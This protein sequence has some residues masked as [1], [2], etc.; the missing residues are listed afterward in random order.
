MHFSIRCGAPY[1]AGHHSAYAT[2]KPKGYYCAQNLREKPTRTPCDDFPIVKGA[3]QSAQNAVF[4]FQAAVF[5]SEAE[6][7][8][9]RAKS[10]D[11]Q[12]NA[13][14]MSCAPRVSQNTEGSGRS[15]GQETWELRISPHNIFGTGR[16]LSAPAFPKTVY[17]PTSRFFQIRRKRGT[18]QVFGIGRFL[19]RLPG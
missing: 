11:S 3:T 7:S 5:C 12:Q 15:R 16:Y 4:R 13:A 10:F 19:G 18:S 9:V 6:G 8:G 1:A 2:S 14:L 17:A